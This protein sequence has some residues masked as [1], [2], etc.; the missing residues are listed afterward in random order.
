MTP[1]EVEKA[2]WDWWWVGISAVVAIGML[3]NIIKDWF[4]D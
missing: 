1:G 3:V 4:K 2:I